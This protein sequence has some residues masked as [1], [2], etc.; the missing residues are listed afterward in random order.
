MSQQPVFYFNINKSVVGE[1]YQEGNQ[2]YLVAILT[3]SNILCPNGAFSHLVIPDDNSIVANSVRTNLASDYFTTPFSNLKFC[4]DLFKGKGVSGSNVGW[5]IK[6]TSQ[7]ENI[8]QPNEPPLTEITFK[9]INQKKVIKE[10][11]A[12][13][14]YHH[15]LEIEPLSSGIEGMPEIS[16]IVFEFTPG[17]GI[18]ID[19]SLNET[20]LYNSQLLAESAGKTFTMKV[21]Q[22]DMNV[23]NN[24]KRLSFGSVFDFDL[25]SFQE[26]TTGNDKNPN[27]GQNSPN[28]PTSSNGNGNKN[29]GLNKGL[30]I[31]GIIIFVV[32]GLIIGFLWARKKNKE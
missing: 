17:G 3:V 20:K 19:K 16:T 13:G 2:K 11:F 28:S 18:P 26:K 32:L 24:Y 25:D 14:C 31:G 29:N 7:V 22:W 8:H 4:P 10:G 21:R 12:E 1:T 23:R 30:I 9:V 27:P 5:I 6:D 15:E